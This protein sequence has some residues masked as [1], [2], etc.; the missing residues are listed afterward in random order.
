M[1]KQIIRKI[2]TIKSLI[3]KILL[4]LILIIGS[5]ATFQYKI[6]TQTLNEMF[7]PEN[8]PNKEATEYFIKAMSMA[9]YIERLHNFVDYDNLLMK[10]FLNKMNEEYE[11][12]KSLL[13]K[14]SAED[15][16]WYVILYRGIYGIGVLTSNNDD[17]LD[18]QKNLKTEDEYKKYYEDILEKIN[19]F[20]NDD[21]SYNAPLVIDTKIKVI[22]SLI[23][24]HFNLI[25]NLIGN[26][27]KFNLIQDKRYLEDINSVYLI[28]NKY[29]QKYLPLVSD[30]S[31]NPL[32]D[33]K[34]FEIRFLTSISVVETEQTNKLNCLSQNYQILLDKIKDLRNFS[35]DLQIEDNARLEYIFKKSIWVKFIINEI[36]ECNNLK[37]DTEEVLKYLKN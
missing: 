20:A 13:P 18:F 12:G 27:R 25:N 16:F 17:S 19:R 7:Q 30:K 5:F 33:N 23:L 9:A 10:P 3:L 37:K 8:S 4:L 32:I 26:K 28:Y 15:I 24:E 35:S 29:A 34:Y 22:N 14:N 21:F 36:K 31:K 6:Q 11:K 1:I 2:F